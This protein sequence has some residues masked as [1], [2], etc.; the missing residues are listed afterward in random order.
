ME[1]ELAARVHKRATT[2]ASHIRVVRGGS[3]SDK[4]MVRMIMLAA[5]HI[6]RIEPEHHVAAALIL[7]WREN[8]GLSANCSA[9]SRVSHGLIVGREWTNP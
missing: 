2:A 4:R 9:N 1:V 3:V 5:I 7:L 8:I 6:A